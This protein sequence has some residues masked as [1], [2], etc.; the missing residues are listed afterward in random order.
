MSV[1]T[2]D[3]V[4]HSDAADIISKLKTATYDDV[5]ITHKGY[6]HGKRGFQILVSGIHTVDD[7]LIDTWMDISPNYTSSVE[8][9]TMDNSCVLEYIRIQKAA[10]N[11][12]LVYLSVFFACI[13]ILWTRH[14]LSPMLNYTSPTSSL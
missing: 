5:E 14:S 9:D 11:F 1:F 3:K 10:S 2:A 4:P 12:W 13:Y 7:T 6:I 8:F